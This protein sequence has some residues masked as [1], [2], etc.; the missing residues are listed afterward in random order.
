MPQRA[1]PDLALGRAGL[2][3]LL[4]FALLLG[5]WEWRWRAYGVTP[6]YR[7][8]DALWAMQ[9]RAVD[10]DGAR[11]VIVGSSRAHFNIQLDIWEQLS[12]ER[13]IQLSMEGTSPLPYLEDL[14]AE[15]SVTGTVFVGYAPNL[16]FGDRP[17]P[18]RIS[19]I[20]HYRDERPSQWMSQRL[21]MLLEPLVAFYGADFAL[22]QVI[23]RWPWPARDGVRDMMRV[24]KVADLGKDRGA[25]TWSK[26]DDDPAY[27]E[28]QT[29]IWSQFFPPPI[30][31]HD[32][33]QRDRLNATREQVIERTAGAVEQIR[34]RGGEV[35]FLRLPSDGPF[36]EVEARTRPREEFWDR[37]IERAEVVGIH[38]EDH[39]PLQGFSLPEW[40]HVSGREADAFT[41][42]LFRVV[43]RERNP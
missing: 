13:P 8:S 12:G 26:L 1:I 30:D 22:F 40:S 21:S 38:F 37:L 18:G 34:A 43:E 7:N 31:E 25:R 42:A 35:V 10:A 27:A 3:A 17:G 15:S 20:E 2:I 4:A 29:R 39:P 24:R 41:E 6:S 23:H 16:Y 5:G 33:A 36:R 9:R 11:T 19:P 28:N 14:A 32:P